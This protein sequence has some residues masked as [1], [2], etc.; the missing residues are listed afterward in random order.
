M[1]TALR[2]TCTQSKQI[3]FPLLIQPASFCVDYPITN[4]SLEVTEVGV[5]TSGMQ[6]TSL[7]NFI[8]A[9]NLSEDT[10]YVFKLSATNSVGTVSTNLSQEIC[11]FNY[12]T[13]TY[14]TSC[15]TAECSKWKFKGIV[16]RY[17]T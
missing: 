12:G 10:I 6:F 13:G 1:F 16:P 15:L 2:Q 7:E 11:K 17:K 9:E 8:K 14:K 5:D 3:F 4:Y